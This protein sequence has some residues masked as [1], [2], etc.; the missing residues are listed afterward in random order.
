MKKPEP[1]SVSIVCTVCGLDWRQHGEKPTLEKCVEL[2]KAELASARARTWT[3]YA[4][5]STGGN[6]TIIPPGPTL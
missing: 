6:L 1:K 2:L 5:G 4:S 3:N